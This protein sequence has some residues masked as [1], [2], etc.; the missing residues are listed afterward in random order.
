M[1]AH[2]NTMRAEVRAGLLYYGP[3]PIHGRNHFRRPRGSLCLI[4]PL[5]PFLF[6]VGGCYLRLASSALQLH[7]RDDP[8]QRA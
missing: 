2:C 5:T 3:T 8:E 7:S 1:Q 6:Q 4:A